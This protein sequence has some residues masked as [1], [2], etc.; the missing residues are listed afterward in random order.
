MCEKRLVHHHFLFEAARELRQNG[1]APTTRYELVTRDVTG[2]RGASGYPDCPFP[3]AAAWL[4]G[5]P[6][7]LWVLAL[8]RAL[9]I[10]GETSASKNHI[11]RTTH[12]IQY[13]VGVLPLTANKATSTVAEKFG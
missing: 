12:T 9:P 5:L 1:Q 10:H 8:I 11:S 13:R 4:R 2:S 6:D 7:F 3:C